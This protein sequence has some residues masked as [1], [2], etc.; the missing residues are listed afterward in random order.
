MGQCLA[1]FN[2]APRSQDFQDAQ[3]GHQRGFSL[4]Y[5]R[6]PKCPHSTGC[7]PASPSRSMGSR[8]E[9]SRAQPS[10]RRPHVDPSCGR[11][12]IE[13]ATPNNDSSSGIFSR[14]ATY[15]VSG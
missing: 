14:D 3:G 2:N 6:S 4:K 1:R 5:P 11:F 9:V 12:L 8:N 10:P 15:T 7:A 13:N